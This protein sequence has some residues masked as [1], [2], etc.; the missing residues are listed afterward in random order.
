MTKNNK[1]KD[2]GVIN[3]YS[4]KSPRM[5]S[6]KNA[7][8][9]MFFTLRE[10]RGYRISFVVEDSRVAGCCDAAADSI[11]PRRLGSPASSTFATSGVS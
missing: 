10:S 8:F 3:S 11:H 1:D 4:W 7:Y 6:K 2:F 9:V 5:N